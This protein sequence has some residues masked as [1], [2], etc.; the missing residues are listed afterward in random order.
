MISIKQ[1]S[2]KDALQLPIVIG[3]LLFLS[4]TYADPPANGTWN[5]TFSD[6]FDGTTLDLLKWDTVSVCCGHEQFDAYNLGSNCIVKDG[7]LREVLRKGSINGSNYLAA[8]IT[9]HYK[10]Q[11]GYFEIRC[12]LP[13]GMGL[14][15]AFWLDGKEPNHYEIDVFEQWSGCQPSHIIGT[16]HKWTGGHDWC[17]GGG[18]DN[19]TF[20]TDYHTF[21]LEWKPGNDCTWYV[22]GKSFGS[23]KCFST[24]DFAAMPVCANFQS[25]NLNF[26]PGCK[27]ID[28]TTPLPAYYDIDYIRVYQNPE[29]E[30]APFSGTPAPIP[31]T[32]E[33]ENFDKGGEGIAY[34][35]DEITNKGNLYR[36]SDGVDI[37]S[38]QDGG[39]SLG[40]VMA[41][42]WTKYTVDVANAAYYDM[43]IIVASAEDGHTFRIEFDGVDKTGALNAPVTGGWDTYKSFTK[44][45]VYLKAGKQVMKFRALVGVNIDKIVFTESGHYTIKNRWKNSYLYD[46]GDRVRYGATPSNSSYYWQMEDIAGSIELKNAASGNYMNIQ[47]QLGYIQ[48]SPHDP[49]WW[50]SRWNLEQADDKYVLF[51]NVWKINQFI[52]VQDQLNHAQHGTI[53]MSW[54]SAQWSL[55]PVKLGSAPI[56]N[57]GKDQT[58]PAGTTTATLNGDGSSDPDNDALTY[59]WKKISGD[60]TTIVSPELAMTDVSDLENGIYQFELNVSDGISHAKDTV[61]IT[62]DNPTAIIPQHLGKPVFSILRAADKRQLHITTNRF[63]N[64]TVYTTTGKAVSS[65]IIKS[66]AEN[67]RIG[68][69]GVY[70][71]KAIDIETGGI[72]LVKPF[73]MY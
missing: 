58:L 10:Q 50:S 16:I 6:E 35:D 65:S 44:K 7:I 26:I 64:V 15:P 62:F 52:H 59:Q 68:R 39:H 25:D 36:L 14:W 51:K 27:P 70:I 47:D 67:I 71:V 17:D 54:L 55:E 28:N 43:T 46:A 9:S 42:E 31:G 38:A 66:S 24:A 72:L 2:M 11:F 1:F 56:A 45:R 13:S 63:C 69:P 19:S 22:D 8:A 49:D 23:K 20:Q 3:V 18:A 40:W 4:V 5:K 53:E 32:V 41:D 48:C 37:G 12:K 60:S 34:H 61:N 21:G 57:A 73:V 33:M 30:L 29:F